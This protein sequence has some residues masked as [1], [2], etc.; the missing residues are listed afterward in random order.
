[1]TCY[2]VKLQACGKTYLFHGGNDIGRTGV[3]YA[4]LAEG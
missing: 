3:G 1:M 2:S 4:E